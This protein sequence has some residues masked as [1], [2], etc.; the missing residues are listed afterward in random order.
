ME[1][2]FVELVAAVF[3]PGAHIF[4]HMFDIVRVAEEDGGVLWLLF[5]VLFWFQTSRICLQGLKILG[6]VFGSLYGY[7]GRVVV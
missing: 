1:G 3:E 6:D 5:Y 7:C 4:L 2:L